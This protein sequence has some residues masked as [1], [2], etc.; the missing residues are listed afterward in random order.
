[1]WLIVAKMLIAL[2][3]GGSQRR[4]LAFAPTWHALRSPSARVRASSRFGA[5]LARVTSACLPILGAQLPWRLPM[6][7]RLSAR[8]SVTST[9]VSLALAKPIGPNSTLALGFIGSP[10]GALAGSGGITTRGS[11]LSSLMSSRARSRLMSSSAS[12]MCIIT[13]VSARARARRRRCGRTWSSPRRS[14]PGSGGAPGSRF[15]TVLRSALHPF[16]CAQGG[17]PY[18]RGSGGRSPPPPDHHPLPAG[19][20]GTRP[21]RRLG[22]IR[23]L[24]PVAGACS[25][26]YRIGGPGARGPEVPGGN[27]SFA[28]PPAGSA[29]RSP[30][31]LLHHV[32]P[33]L[34]GAV[35]G[36]EAVVELMD[37]GVVRCPTCGWEW[38]GMS[39]CDHESAA[40]WP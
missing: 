35:S 15:A 16:C 21:R 9:G 2:S 32:V 26:T 17:L 25:F 19:M 3:L 12:P 24:A 18:A 11:R 6:L 30:L 20:G 13:L 33:L 31:V 5:P 29:V 38:D 27:T 8:L 7:H 22:P 40:Y 36:G 10:L 14:T 37:S 34:V 28:G 1:M 39:Q 4:A 23:R